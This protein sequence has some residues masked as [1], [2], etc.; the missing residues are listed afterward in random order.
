MVIDLTHPRGSV[1]LVHD[2]LTQR[3]GAERVVL[4][5]LAAFPD[6]PLHTSFFHADGTF[7]EV[8]S[9]RIRTL[10]ID[11]V[12]PLR[13]HHRVAF[14]LLA[15]SFARY[16]VDADVVLCSSSGWAHGVRTDGRKIVYCHAPAR[17]LYQKDEYLKRKA[18]RIEL[19]ALST[20]GRPLR[21]W[22]RKAAGSAHR[23][24]ANSTLIR[25]L[26]WSIYGIDAEVVPPPV[27][28]DASGEQQPMPGFEPGGF[29]L[30]V[31]R[32]LAYKNVDN[33]IKAFSALR[34]PLVIVGE[35]PEEARLRSIAGANAFMVGRVTDA[36]LRWL[37]ANC[38]ANVSAS[39]EDFGLTTIEAAAFGKP[40][41]AL[42]YGGFLDTIV[43]GDTG[44]LFDEPQ[45]GHIREA[46]RTAASM[47]WSDQAIAKHS[48]T[49]SPAGFRNRMRQIVAEE[50][51][52][53][54]H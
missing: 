36:E 11:K 54:P 32:L 4:E 30:V 21:S 53:A 25:D 20:L 28:V 2:Y 13:R 8:D 44:L 46:V 47:S 12:A 24:L 5:L 10:P 9:S 17:W 35:G 27:T 22:D 3:G 14:P 19:A 41:I 23:Y 49:F 16:S 45:P 33:V 42:R 39:K 37:Y 31:S 38:A 29:H 6:S 1:A 7:P 43:E 34:T 48:A 52:S 50:L 18:Q 51:R 40:T 26:I 15:P